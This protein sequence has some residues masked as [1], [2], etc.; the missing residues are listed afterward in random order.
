MQRAIWNFARSTQE[1]TPDAHRSEQFELLPALRKKR[2]RRRFVKVATFAMRNRL[3][4][5]VRI[6]ISWNKFGSSFCFLLCRPLALA[7]SACSAI[8]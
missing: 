3:A 1:R 7:F 5:L 2:L 4:Q 8:S 6:R